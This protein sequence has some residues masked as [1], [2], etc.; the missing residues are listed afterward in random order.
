MSGKP[1]TAR[2]LVLGLLAVTWIICV[3]ASIRHRDLEWLQYIRIDVVW[4][5]VLLLGIGVYG[6]ILLVAGTVTRSGRQPLPSPVP[7]FVSIILPAKD[8]QAVI[9][10]SVRSLCALDYSDQTGRPMFEVIV[11]DD[12][13]TDQTAGI[14]S[15]LSAE[16]P[17]RVVRTAEGS[18]G[19][20]AALNRGVAVS[21]GDLLAVFDADA[22]VGP[23]FLRLMVAQAGG[24]RTGGVQSRRMVYNAA[25]NHVTRR[26]DDEYRVVLHAL[27]QARQVLGGMVS[28][29]G[30]GLLVRRTALDDVG[31]W[32]EDALTEDLDL[33]TRLHLAGWEI[34]YCPEAVVWEEAVPTLRQFIRQRARWFEGS[35]GCLG[36]YLPSIL[37]SRTSLF[38]RL[39]ML[40]FLAGSLFVLLGVVTTNLYG[41]PPLLG[42]LVLYLQLPRWITTWLP[43]AGL[44]SLIISVIV[45]VRGHL[46]EAAMLI[47]RL[48]AFSLVTPIVGAI[49]I[50]RYVRA[51]ITGRVVWDKTLHGAVAPEE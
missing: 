43:S 30:N 18:V 7:A 46:R 2:H 22:R 5:Q 19:K 32:K 23:D 36:D 29:V 13:S 40:L 15:R 37:F 48:L 44:V 47:A 41:V 11:V 20:A 42:S 12:C 28:F 31:G 6:T 38:K 24:E 1:R 9:E 50:R 27:Q 33:S 49:A 21:R 35:L 26:Q 10:A 25:M 14:L 16:L 8:E 3:L 4:L 39:D 17:I 45:A 51:A 34:Q